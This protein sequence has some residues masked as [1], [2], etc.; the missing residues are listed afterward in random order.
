M[1]RKWSQGL[2][3]LSRGMVFI[4]SLPTAFCVDSVL[5]VN[6]AEKHAI[7]TV[8]NLYAEPLHYDSISRNP[9]NGWLYGLVITI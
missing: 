6:R 5:N 3:F 8:V 7:L 4:R 1:T 2:E 9:T